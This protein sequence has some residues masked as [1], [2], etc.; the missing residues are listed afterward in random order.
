ML[1]LAGRFGDLNESAAL[2]ALATIQHRPYVTGM[3]FSGDSKQPGPLVCSA[4]EKIMFNEF[5]GQTSLSLGRRLIRAG[6][7]RIVVSEQSRV[8][9]IL[10]EWSN[11]VNYAGRLTSSDIAK[12]LTSI[13]L[14]KA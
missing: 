10:V 4:Q 8:R 9:P 11:E 1:T 5:A 2:V 12:A 6:V 3:F 7:D 13:A 14:S